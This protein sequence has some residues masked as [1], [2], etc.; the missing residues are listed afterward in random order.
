MGRAPAWCSEDVV[1]QPLSADIAFTVEQRTMPELFAVVV[2]G[3][4]CVIVTVFV[5]IIMSHYTT[6]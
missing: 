4:D 5:F 3:G 1:V 2:T 6:C